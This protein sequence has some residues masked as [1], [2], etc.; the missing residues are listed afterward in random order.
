M[1]F[2]SN[3]LEDFEKYLLL[4]ISDSQLKVIREEKEKLNVLKVRLEYKETDIIYLTKQGFEYDKNKKKWSMIKTFD[5]GRYPGDYKITIEFR[6]DYPKSAPLIYA[7]PLNGIRHSQH[8]LDGNIVC[9]A[10][11]RGHMPNSYWK[12]Y[13]NV[14]GALLLSYHVIADNLDKNVKYNKEIANCN[15]KRLSEDITGTIFEDIKKVVNK[16]TFIKEFLKEKNFIGITTTW[17]WEEIAFTFKTMSTKHKSDLIKYYKGK[18]D[19]KKK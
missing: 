9:V 16:K 14:K 8:I 15:N 4:S 12:E 3:I 1:G 10:S 5:Y 2:I 6:D 11:D 17:T 13:M 19:A 7:K 18:K